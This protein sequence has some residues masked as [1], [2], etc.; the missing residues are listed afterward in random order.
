M[1]LLHV[2]EEPDDQGRADHLDFW[3]GY[4]ELGPH[5]DEDDIDQVCYCGGRLVMLK[6]LADDAMG[7]EVGAVW[8]RMRY[9]ADH[10]IMDEEE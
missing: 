6:E 4:P 7:R 2:F 1:H 3:L 5:Y 10:I 8:H 9:D